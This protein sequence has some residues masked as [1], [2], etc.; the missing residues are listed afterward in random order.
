MRLR[1]ELAAADQV[2]GRLSRGRLVA[3]ASSG[4][5]C[6]GVIDFLTGYAV[7]VS[8]F[9]LAPVALSAWYVSW[10]SSVWIAL[11]SCVC[12]V[13]ADLLAGLPY[14]EPGVLVWNTLVQ[15][16]FLLLNG[17]LVVGLRS[18]LAH[19]RKLART[20]PLTGTFTR[21]AFEERLDHDIQLARRHGSPL[22]LA[23]VDLDHFKALNDTRGHALGDKALRIIAGVL[24]DVTRRSD[25]VARLGGDEFALL[26]PD[27]TQ[28][29]ARHV[30]DRVRSEL[31]HQLDIIAPE[32]TCSIG[33]ITFQKPESDPDAM[34]RA[35]D[36]LMYAAKHRGRNMVVFNVVSGRQR[37][38]TTTIEKLAATAS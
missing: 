8:E 22:T 14:G 1:A 12:W 13:F 38:G 26:L 23:F 31:R 7:S 5:G 21:R 35:A 27:A 24:K 17:F 30:I 20:D 3:L 4:V 11:L 29:S 16:G 33:V 18:S 25:T 32:V 15:F 6:I 34:L 28:A 10:R 2:L 9:Y 36:A 37:L 19:Q